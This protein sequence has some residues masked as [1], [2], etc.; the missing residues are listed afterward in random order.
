MAINKINK[1]KK[2]IS[3]VILTILSI[4]WILPVVWVIGTSFK[5]EQEAVSSS[6]NLIPQDFTLESY[7]YI[8]SDTNNNILHYIKNSIIISSTHTFLY[9]I[10]ASLAAYAYGVMKWKHRDKV[11]WAL[12]ATM[13]I[14][15][16]MNLVPLYA[17]MIKLKWLDKML[18]LII[19]GLGG[20]FGIF[21]L[22]QFFLGIPKDL[23]ESAKMDGA[24]H[25]Y[26]YT[27][28][29]LPLSKSAL[30]VVGLFSFVGN[31]NDYLWPLIVLNTDTNRTLP[32]G[33]ALMQGNYNIYYSRLMAA[34]VVSMLPVIA[35]FMVAQNSFIK[36]ISMT[37]IKE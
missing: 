13:M 12:L 32:I 10:V 15:T 18:A 27:K 30:V 28:I 5:T 16:V 19:P 1:K 25:F 36:G 23:V 20:V 22:R 34:T 4:M 26:I 17:I 8:F 3:F 35:I 24:N 33:L 14:P 7:K 2:R 9:L 6:I 31:W 11:F 29:V 37:G 21:L